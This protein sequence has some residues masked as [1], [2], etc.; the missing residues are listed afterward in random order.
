MIFA[1]SLNVDRLSEYLCSKRPLIVT[2]DDVD[3][4]TSAAMMGDLYF[5]VNG[6]LPRFYFGIRDTDIPIQD[7]DF[8]IFLDG[9]PSDEIR[10]RLGSLP[11]TVYDHHYGRVEALGQVIDAPVY[12]TASLVLSTFVDLL[13]SGGAGLTEEALTNL[14]EK[15]LP[16]SAMAILADY[17]HV[18]KFPV[19]EVEDWGVA[20]KSLQSVL[21]NVKLPKTRHDVLF[22]YAPLINSAG[23]LGNAS[24]AVKLFMQNEMHKENASVLATSKEI[25]SAILDATLN[26]LLPELIAMEPRSG[27]QEPLLVTLSPER[28]AFKG[29]VASVITRI[30]NRPSVVLT[31]TKKGVEGSVRLPALWDLDIESYLTELINEGLLISPGGH[32]SAGGFVL[33]NSLV[34]RNEF[35]EIEWGEIKRTL[36]ERLPHISLPPA[37]AVDRITRS[38]EPLLTLDF[39]KPYLVEGLRVG[40]VVTVGRQKQHLLVT[41]TDKDDVSLTTLLT[42]ASYTPIRKVLLDDGVSHASVVVEGWTTCRGLAPVVKT[43]LTNEKVNFLG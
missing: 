31:S 1:P 35:G 38:W 40:R 17:L 36:C 32:K 8:V 42:Y 10:A 20:I 12:A 14:I 19:E 30:T 29:V 18:G 33:H 21:K 16:A 7:A 11:Y 43:L 24:A 34:R 13:N 5:R 28:S 25:Q 22:Y 39:T 26:D 15:H 2:D 41:L 4:C 27:E 6:Y 9:T 37:V 23:R 3:G